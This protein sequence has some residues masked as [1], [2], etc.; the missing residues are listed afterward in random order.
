[1]LVAAVGMYFYLGYLETTSTST[2]VPV[3]ISW[4]YDLGGKELVAAF[5]GVLG[6]GAFGI[7]IA[8]IANKADD[9]V[10]LRN[11]PPIAASDLTR[12][13]MPALEFTPDDLA[14]NQRGQITPAQQAKLSKLSSSSTKWGL[15]SGLIMLVIFGG[16]GA[17]A[18][19][20]APSAAAMRASITSDPQTAKI[21]AIAAGIVALLVFGSLALA[22]LRAR[23]VGK[24]N[25]RAVEGK[26]NLTAITMNL[27]TRLIA[28]AVGGQG[29]M[30][31]IKIGGMKFYV[32]EAVLAAFKHQAPYRIYY[33]KNRP[34]HILLAAEA[35]A[36]A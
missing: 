28:K 25:L 3:L 22:L 17:Y 1:M 7:G 34:T 9:T 16:I 23:S 10:A 20:F 11:A 35:L 26:V 6:L 2:S 32:S 18:L 15:I 21:L 30:C 5:F 19:Y 36:A 12:H 24:G 4:L 8:G 13:L 27:E 33:V 29:R 31:M 14:A